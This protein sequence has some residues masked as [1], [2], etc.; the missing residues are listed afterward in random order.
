MTIKMRR[1]PAVPSRLLASLCLGLS[2]ALAPT[3]K[4]APA[5]DLQVTNTGPGA[6]YRFERFERRGVAILEGATLEIRRDGCWRTDM[7]FDNANPDS[8]EVS[9]SYRWY[10][11]HG[12]TIASIPGVS[13]Q[14]V[15]PAVRT[16]ASGRGCSGA[17][18]RNYGTLARSG[19]VR[20]M[21]VR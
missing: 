12:R 19:V 18:S 6:L 14:T 1:L 7:V 2:I 3:G 20:V 11:R 10:D 17:I 16:S 13:R 15:D 4:P 5:A 8:R 9:V 21:S